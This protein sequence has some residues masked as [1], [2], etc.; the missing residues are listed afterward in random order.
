MS[1][2]YELGIIGAGQMGYAIAEGAVKSGVVSGPNILAADPF[3]T[4]QKKAKWTALGINC[5][6]DNPEVIRK[7]KMVVLSVK[8][9]LLSE[10][11]E[12]L[13][14]MT[15]SQT[16]VSVIAGVSNSKL[17]SLCGSANIVRVMLN[18]ACLIGAGAVSICAN[19]GT[20]EAIVAE[21]ENVFSATSGCIQRVPERCMD[22]IT[23]LA[24]SGVAFAYQFIEALSDGGVYSGLPRELATKLAAQTVL[25]NFLFLKIQKMDIAPFSRWTYFCNI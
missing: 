8:P 21:V 2:E 19:P 24:G 22:G 9:Q 5:T 11:T 23:A 3:R 4:E 7:C 14:G 15:N 16:V 25:G 1:F 10:V 20:P 18:T 13:T 17:S 6:R 12:H